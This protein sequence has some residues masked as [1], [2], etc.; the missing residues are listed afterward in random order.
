VRV[1]IVFGAV[2]WPKEHDIAAET[3]IAV[4]VPIDSAEMGGGLP[5]P[6]V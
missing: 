6:F 2:T 1:D 4:P 5:A 3:L